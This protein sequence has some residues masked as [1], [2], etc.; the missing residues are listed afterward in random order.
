MI[1]TKTLSLKQVA[2][3]D[4]VGKATRVVF[5]LTLGVVACI[6][7]Y[8]IGMFVYES[9]Y[10]PS[11]PIIDHGPLIG[12]SNE[13]APFLLIK[14]VGWM[15]KTLCFTGLSEF[16]KG[17]TFMC[18]DKACWKPLALGIVLLLVSMLFNLAGALSC[19]C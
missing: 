15:G 8:V 14:G 5:W 3:V 6:I 16:V 19:G 9:L 13:Q 12:G 11:A 1:E 17:I 18:V 2:V 10:P 4:F 7:L